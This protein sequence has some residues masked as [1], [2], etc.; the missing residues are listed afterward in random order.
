M[1][2]KE[3][4]NRGFKLNREIE[5]LVEAKENAKNLACTAVSSPDGERVQTSKKNASENKFIRYADYS[6]K[7]YERINEL[8][9]IQ[10]EIAEA[11][12]HVDD[13]TLRC[14]LTAR[15]INFKT[16][17]VICEELSFDI[18]GKYIFK[19]HRTAL[20]KIKDILKL[21]TE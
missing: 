17:D 16:W 20:K 9:D 15:Y 19:L 6:L 3:W 5:Q 1:T 8:L 14:L 11:I 4:L 10:K 21:D 2:A 18:D 12:S 7:L 13:T